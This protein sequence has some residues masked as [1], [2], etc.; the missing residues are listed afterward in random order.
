MKPCN[1][2]PYRIKSA[3]G[4]LGDSSYEPE[5]FLRQLDLPGV[6]PCHLSVDWEDSDIEDIESAPICI[7]ALQFMNNSCK[8]HRSEYIRRMQ[9]QAGKNTSIISFNHNFIE[10]HSKKQK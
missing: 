6:H 10:H 2:C 4:Y 7:G 1:E 3:P 5:Q 9:R 8:S